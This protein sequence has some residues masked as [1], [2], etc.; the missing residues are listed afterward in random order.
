[1]SNSGPSR[2]NKRAALGRFGAPGS[3]FMAPKG[4]RAHDTNMSVVGTL[5][6]NVLNANKSI[7]DDGDSLRGSKRP[8]WD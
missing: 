1:M 2:E 6:G 5:C 4:A 3:E 8:E 7:W